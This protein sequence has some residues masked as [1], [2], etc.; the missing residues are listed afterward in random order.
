MVKSVG[1]KGIMKKNYL[2]CIEICLPIIMFLIFLT[3]AYE[4][5][6]FGESGSYFPFL[7]IG[8]IALV[9]LGIN[10][11][12]KKQEIPKQVKFV[13]IIDIIIIV[14]PIIYL[15]PILFN[16][17]SSVDATLFEITRYIC[18]ALIYFILKYT[19][20]LKGYM[21]GIVLLAV[22]LSITGIDALTLKKFENWFGLFYENVEVH[23]L[24]GLIH[25]SN[26]IA[27]I[28]YIA[29]L[30]LLNSICFY[31]FDKNK[32]NN[33]KYALLNGFKYSLI[34]FFYSIVLLCNSRMVIAFYI[35]TSLI[36]LVYTLKNN[37]FYD[38]A[39]ILLTLIVP[40]GVTSVVNGLI[41][42]N[43]V[44]Y[45]Y[46]IY[47]IIFVNFSVL[48]LVYYTYVLSRKT[49]PKRVIKASMKTKIAM[50]GVVIIF[51]TLVLSIPHK[52]TIINNTQ[53]MVQQVRKTDDFNEGKNS[54]FVDITENEIS[55]YKINLYEITESKEISQVL[56]ISNDE[57]ENGIINREFEMT[58][59]SSVLQISIDVYEGSIV[60]NSFKINDKNIVLSYLLLPDDIA[61]KIKETFLSDA[62]N[63][64][65]WLYYKD[66]IKM[67]KL[68]PIIGNGGDTFFYRYLQVQDENY[69]STEAHSYIMQLLIEV[70]IIGL[71][72]YLVFLI[73]MVVL[74]VKLIKKRGI[75]DVLIYLI[76][77]VTFVIMSSFDVIFSFTLIMFIFSMLIGLCVNEYIKD[78][79]TIKNKKGYVLKII[80]AILLLLIVIRFTLNFISSKITINVNEE[81]ITKIYNNVE[82]AEN[83]IKLDMYSKENISQ[84][85]YMYDNYI[86]VLQKINGNTYTIDKYIIRQKEL[87]DKLLKLEYNNYAMDLLALDVYLYH[88]DDY[89]EINFDKKESI[90]ESLGIYMDKIW[91]L[92]K[93]IE[94]LTND[95]FF[96]D[97]AF[98]RAEQFLETD[99]KIYKSQII[100][101]TINKIKGVIEKL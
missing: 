55:V 30:Y 82:I 100:E 32:D 76:L 90:D 99:N 5:G 69:T 50:T 39:S 54:V 62:N 2:K 20:N 34:I 67:F 79:S 81:D 18:M 27:I 78:N 70:G 86:N 51:M 96:T 95:N 61:F 19:G 47:F 71:T 37:K 10:I 92:L 65:R 17:Q 42:L 6:G 53:E 80:L 98:K 14:F 41:L 8:V 75:K 93:K 74:F 22:I 28:I 24:T 46:L 73:C 66:S 48:T 77:F 83:R 63:S 58:S 56:T 87:T 35:I 45:I 43:S 97:Y 40:F 94:E 12:S 33:I 9:L 25:Y 57:F 91:S 4:D 59:A 52:L 89:V 7:I 68:S 16:K 84:I 49:N 64:L 60:V 15:L 11:I 3:L 101:E 38:S 36:Y 21:R 88:Y 72:I 44:F 26:V 13:T 29:S 1:K 23:R 31:D 85:I